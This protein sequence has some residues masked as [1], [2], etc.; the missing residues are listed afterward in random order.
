[1]SL[2]HLVFLGAA[3]AAIV[4]AASCTI[5]DGLDAKVTGAEGGVDGGGDTVAPPDTQPGYLSLSDGVAFCSNAFACSLLP[6]GVEFSV[7]VP[8]DSNN[9]SSCV[10]WVSGPLPKDRV[11]HDSTA[12]FL[13]CAAK[14]TSCADASKCFWYEPLATNDPRCAGLDAGANGACEEDA[15]ALYFCAAGNP[16]IEHCSNAFFPAGFSCVTGA[17]GL[18]YCAGKTC[19]GDQCNGSFLEFCGATNKLYNGQDC[20]AGGFTCGFDSTEG[21]ND[22][23]TNGVAK[24][25]SALAVACQGDVVAICDGAFESHY[26]CSASGGTCDQTAFPRCKLPG[27]TCTPMDANVNVCTGSSISLCV[28]GQTTSFDCASIGKT[29][30]PGQNGKSGHCG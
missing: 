25:C 1:M 15:S 3:G 30:V 14:A 23:L 19:A 24:T 27:E 22:C 18:P 9:F 5:F 16:A 4:V 8:V 2:K 26:D 29:C 13:D 10:G 20:S 21:Y 6:S 7:D 17:D 28:G 11:G 12:K